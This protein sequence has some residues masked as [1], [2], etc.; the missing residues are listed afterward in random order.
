MSQKKFILYFHLSMI[1]SLFSQRSFSL[2]FHL[3]LVKFA[4][5]YVLQFQ[6][7]GQNFVFERSPGRL[8]SL[9]LQTAAMA[10]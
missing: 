6:R 2:Y 9:V 8:P 10:Q 1:K 7:L 3:S 4:A 5:A